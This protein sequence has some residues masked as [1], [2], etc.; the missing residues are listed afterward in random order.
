MEEPAAKLKDGL[1]AIELAQI[2]NAET[3]SCCELHLP[4]HSDCSRGTLNQQVIV[5][6]PQEKKTFL[7]DLFQ[8]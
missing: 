8:K 6:C 5:E 1:M 3:I 7:C 4:K 2:E